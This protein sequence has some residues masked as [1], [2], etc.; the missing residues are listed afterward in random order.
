METSEER[1]PLNLVQV[2]SREFAY[3][4]LTSLRRVWSTAKARERSEAALE[5]HVYAPREDRPALLYVSPAVVY[6][7]QVCGVPFEFLGELAREELP[8]GAQLVHLSDDVIP[9]L[10]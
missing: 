1:E 8:T 10:T 9:P 5:V 2:P 3:E 4:V 7:L 6:W